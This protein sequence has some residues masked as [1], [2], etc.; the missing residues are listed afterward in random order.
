M[1]PDFADWWQKFIDFILWLPRFIY[2]GFV[3]GGIYTIDQIF[4]Y[5]TG[6]NNITSVSASFNSLLGGV[7][8]GILYLLTWFDIVQGLQTISCAVIIRFFIRRLPFIG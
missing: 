5:C 1:I 6:C 2:Q 7:P 3:D 4:S 8:S